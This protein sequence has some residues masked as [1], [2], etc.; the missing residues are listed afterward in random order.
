MNPNYALQ[1]PKDNFFKSTSEHRPPVKN[2]LSEGTTG[3]LR[4]SL[5]FKAERG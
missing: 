4:I 2:L 5:V 3:Y 1:T